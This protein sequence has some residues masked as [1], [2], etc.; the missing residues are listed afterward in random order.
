M[1][2]AL[3]AVSAIVKF[4]ELRE[5]DDGSESNGTLGARFQEEWMAHNVT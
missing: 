3:A 4:G 5:C 1:P 2:I